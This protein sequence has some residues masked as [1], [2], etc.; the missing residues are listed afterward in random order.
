MRSRLLI[1]NQQ[2]QSRQGLTGTQRAACAVLAAIG[3]AAAAARLAPPRSPA[4]PPGGTPARSLSAPLSDP[5]QPIQGPE[6]V[7]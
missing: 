6:V 3:L 4:T 5:M 2:G 7:R 1:E